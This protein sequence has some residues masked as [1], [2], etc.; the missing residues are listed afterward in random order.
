MPGTDTLTSAAPHTQA[1][2][3]PAGAASQPGR[4]LPGWWSFIEDRLL[5]NVA[6]ILM[7]AAIGIMFY[8]ASSRS[9]LSESHWWAEELVRFM[10]VWSVLLSLGVGTRH[11]HYIRMDLLLNMMPQGLRL[12]FSWVNSLIG[13]GFSVLLVVAGIQ[14]VAHLQAIGMFTESNLDLPLWMVRLVLPLGGVLYGF[15]FIGNIILLLR[16][17]DPDPPTEGENL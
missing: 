8:E 11:G 6:T 5:L 16:G 15:A 13:L 17:Q 14:E 10:V 2:A 12:A 9:L 3:P 4:G 1:A 7:M